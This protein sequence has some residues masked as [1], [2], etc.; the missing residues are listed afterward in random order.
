MN[1]ALRILFL[2]ATYFPSANGVAISVKSSA[3]MLRK[4]GHH[5]TIVAP[6]NPEYLEKD[7]D[8][9]RYSSLPNPIIKDYPIPILPLNAKIVNL[10]LN[11]HYDIVHTH[12]P[13]HIAAFAERYAK[14]FKV[15]LVFTYHT[16]YESYADIYLNFLPKNFRTKIV[17]LGTDY[18][19][20]NADLI[21]APSTTLQNKLKKEY[22]K[23]NIVKLST[24]VSFEKISKTSSNLNKLLKRKKGQKFILVLSR[25]A[26]EKNI[27]LAINSLAKLPNNFHLLIAGSG[28]EEDNLKK[29]AH[30]KKVF[31][32]ITFLGKIDHNEV[33]NILK[34]INIFIFTSTT[35]TQ[36]LCLL[37][38]MY[39]GVPIVAVK[40]LLSAEWI[41]YYAG[42]LVKNNAIEF[43]KAIVELDE[44]QELYPQQLIKKWANKFRLENTVDDLIVSY[45]TAI[46]K[47]NS[48]KT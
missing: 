15:P 9:I 40:S 5:V 30:R 46:A 2:T 6:E 37:E 22:P 1:K 17:K 20:K 16:K 25:L 41:P 33:L 38:S 23:S 7:L 10:I 47:K 44:N 13:F 11:G 29:L 14:K 26:K 8:L 42:K 21:I 18:V 19:C 24:G 36:G 35:E 32:R 28:P 48:D 39:A 4:K 3:D 45:H 43:A 12:H 31:E 34:K 27:N